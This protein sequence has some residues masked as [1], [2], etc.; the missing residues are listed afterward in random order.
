VE[1]LAEVSRL[2][3]RLERAAERE[4]AAPAWPQ[5]M[6]LDAAGAPIAAAPAC[7]RLAP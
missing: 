3:A 2:A 4:G 1:R 5:R 6:G 7:V